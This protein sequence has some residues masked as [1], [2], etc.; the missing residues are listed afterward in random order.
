MINLLW[1]RTVR[2]IANFQ[3]KLK[4]SCFIKL[5]C[6]SIELPP[7]IASHMQRFGGVV[8][9]GTNNLNINLPDNNAVLRLEVELRDKNP[10]RRANNQMRNKGLGGGGGGG[11]RKRTTPTT[12]G[13]V[14]VRQA[15]SP[16]SA[17]SSSN[18]F[19]VPMEKVS[20]ILI[21]FVVVIAAAVILGWHFYGNSIIYIFSVAVARCCFGLSRISGRKPVGHHKHILHFYIFVCV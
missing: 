4:V 17:S 13:V 12:A 21:L 7:A 16:S 9:S 1:R 14:G 20:V 3:I 11:D 2:T 10:R 18:N 19:F 6:I 8:P 5:V 15:P